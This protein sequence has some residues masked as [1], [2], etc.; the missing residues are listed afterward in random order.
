MKCPK[1][2]SDKT[3]KVSVLD[4][5]WKSGE[6]R[7]NSCGY[8][9]YWCNFCED[10]KLARWAKPDETLEELTTPNKNK[11]DEGSGEQVISKPARCVCGEELPWHLVSV[12]DHR[13]QHICSCNRC[14]AYVDKRTLRLDGTEFNPFLGGRNR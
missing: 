5:K 4:P 3:S 11:T 12:S 13:Y 2:G 1:C 6:H 14:Y 9:N 7:C 10:P 8:H